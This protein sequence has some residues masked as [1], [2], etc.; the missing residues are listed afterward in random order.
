MADYDTFIV[1][2]AEYGD[3][4]D[5]EADYQAIKDLYHEFDIV[6][7]FDAAVLSKDDDG[8]VRIVRKHEQ[9]TRTGGWLGGGVG[10]ATGVVVALF[11]AAAIGAGLVAATTAGG[12]AIGALA[13]H[14]VGGM[15]RHDLKELG[16]SMDAGDSGLVVV[17]AVDMEARV[18]E[19]LR[20]SDKII[21]KEIKADRKQLEKEL[22]EAEKLEAGG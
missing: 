1:L 13:G 15:T 6:D 5:A 4:A 14:A 18:D 8:K 3:V 2:A 20:R 7:T 19:A 9:P 22:K 16:E 10:L 11:P 21:R 12:A 17:A